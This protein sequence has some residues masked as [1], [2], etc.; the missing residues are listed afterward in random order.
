MADEDLHRNL[1]ENLR[2]HVDRLA[3]LIGPRHVGAPRSLEAA[4]VLIERQLGDYGYDVERQR[5]FAACQEVSNLVAEVRGT[6]RPEQIVVL[7]AHYDT[8]PGTPGADDNASAVAVLLEVVRMMREQRPRK[9]VRYV[10][11]ACEEPPHFYTGEM[12]SQVYARRCRE[13]SEQVVGMLC[14]EMVG[15]YSSQKGS[16]RIPEAIP[17]ILR[18]IFPRRGNFL[19]A[20]GNMRLM[21]TAVAISAWLQAVGIDPTVFDL[22]AGS[23]Q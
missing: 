1:V 14:L 18:R 2:R 5:Y 17:K 8:V 19:A 9:T 12:G 10:A 3:G 15:Y 4:A 21:E 16:Q 13:K 20:V 7:G 22:P 6:K 11:F 23:G